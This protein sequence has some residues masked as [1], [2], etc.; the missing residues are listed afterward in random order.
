MDNNFAVLTGPNNPLE[1]Y[2]SANYPKSMQEIENFREMPETH[3]IFS[4]HL[5]PITFEEQLQHIYKM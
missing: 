3:K 4:Y 1:K 5:D 2:E